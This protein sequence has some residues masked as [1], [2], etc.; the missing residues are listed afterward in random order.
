MKTTF[1]AI[2]SV[3]L[4]AA[5]NNSE[6]GAD[7][8][9]NFE[10]TEIIVSAEATGRLLTFEVEEGM[11]L[12]ANALVGGIDSVQL[13]LRKAQLGANIK[14]VLSK[15]PEINPQLEVIRQQIATQQKEK[16]RI[17]NLL[18][19]NAATPKQLDD[20]NAAI[21][22]LEKQYASTASTL[23][24][25]VSGITSETQPLQ[26]QVQ[27]VNEQLAQSRVINPVAGTVL[28]K[29]VEK[30]EVVNYGKPLY[31][32]ADL[33]TMYLR[34]YVSGAQLPQ[35]K[36]GQQVTVQTDMPGG[37]MKNWP[38]TV[39]WIA[40]EAEFTPKTIQTREERVQL[41]YAVK[42]RVQ[43]DGSLKIGMPA[44]FRIAK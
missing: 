9:G 43:N 42:I 23:N 41:V 21:A 16:L 8:Y 20:I 15:K 17:Q 5:C 25:Q 1:T 40:S 11:Q 12:A 19:A 3:A 44:E 2:L 7:G 26:L 37:T 6:N 38:G 30:G 39:S 36:M 14:A 34:A 24:T 31:K 4:L 18:K 27:Q 10:S 32:I 33:S 22:V 29:Y 28:T 13:N 35:L